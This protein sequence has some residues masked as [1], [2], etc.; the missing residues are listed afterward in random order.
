MCIDSCV[1]SSN[2]YSPCVLFAN[3]RMIPRQTFLRETQ[4]DTVKR[5]EVEAVSENHK[6]P[7]H[8]DSIFVQALPYIQEPMCV[9][10]V[11]VVLTTLDLVGN[12]VCKFSTVHESKVCVCVDVVLEHLI[13]DVCVVLGQQLPETDDVRKKLFRV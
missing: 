9:M 13:F 12:L 8:I 10:R 1:A 3:G 11:V 4:Y 5:S 2:R 7:S 6:W